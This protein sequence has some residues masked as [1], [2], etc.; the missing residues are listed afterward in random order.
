[1]NA[2]KNDDNEAQM[3]EMGFS[4]GKH[5][6][7]R[8]ERMSLKNRKQKIFNKHAERNFKKTKVSKAISGA[9]KLHDKWRNPIIEDNYNEYKPTHKVTWKSLGMKPE[10]TDTNTKGNVWPRGLSGALSPFRKGNEFVVWAPRETD[11]TDEI[12][13]TYTKFYTEI[14]TEEIQIKPRWRQHAEQV[15]HMMRSKL[16]F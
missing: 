13:E 5:V 16:G 11:K 2:M 3:L 12:V 8:R 4:E 15:L 7:R 14:Y 6:K 10:S 9:R 1:M